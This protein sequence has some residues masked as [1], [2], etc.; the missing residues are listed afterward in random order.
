[1]FL[2]QPYTCTL[3][4]TYSRGTKVI[5]IMTLSNKLHIIN[6]HLENTVMNMSTN[7][8]ISNIMLS[9]LSLGEM[10]HGCHLQIEQMIFVDKY[11]HI[12]NSDCNN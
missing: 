3:T 1:M 8:Y 11:K 6:C 9:I 5:I 7:I 10:Y 2:E 12:K 4:Q